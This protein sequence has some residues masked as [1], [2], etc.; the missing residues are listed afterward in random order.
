MVES[1]YEIDIY[2]FTIYLY[3]SANSARCSVRKLIIIKNGY[4]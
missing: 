1:N 2:K 4:N 3:V